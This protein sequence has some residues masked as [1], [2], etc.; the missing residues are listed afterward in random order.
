MSHI[1]LGE[2]Y[3]CPMLLLVEKPFFIVT[4]A[5]ATM[6]MQHPAPLRDGRQQPNDRTERT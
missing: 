4:L 5:L 6:Q 3:S 1:R 2:G